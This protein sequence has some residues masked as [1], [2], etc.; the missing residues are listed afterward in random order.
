MTPMLAATLF[1]AIQTTA[2]STQ[3]TTQPA[4][5]PAEPIEII[6]AEASSAELTPQ[7]VARLTNAFEQSLVVIEYVWEG[8]EGRQEL[9]GVGIL[10]DDGVVMAPLD[11]V[12]VV[13]PDAQVSDFKIKVPRRDGDPTEYDAILAGRDERSTVTYFEL[14]EG[15]EALPESARPVKFAETPL[16]PGQPLVSIG[17]LPESAGYT[18]FTT[19]ARVA[20][21]LRG[22]KPTVLVDGNLAGTGAVVFD[23]DGRAVGFVDRFG[24]RSPFLTGATALDVVEGLPQLF[25][26]TSFLAPSLADRPTGGVDPAIPYLGIAR[27][28]GV[29]EDLRDYYGLGDRPAVQVGDIIAGSPADE[30]DV[31]TGDVIV[32][33]DGE[34]LE[35]GDTAD[36][37]PDI[38]NRNIGRKAP[39]TQVT[40]T[41]LNPAREER[42]V[43]V[44][45]GE[46][47]M[48]ARSAERWYAEDLGFSVRELVLGDRY[49]RKIALDSPG[50]A[51]AFVRPQSNA[52]AANL[53]VGDLVRRVNQTQVEDLAQFRE[54]YEAFRESNADDPVVLEV[55]SQGDT[56]IVR[57]E[58]PQ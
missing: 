35:R 52:A 2:P 3:S 37:Q 29:S 56:R 48:Q 33:V 16:M 39:G 44:T 47:P 11:L 51:V 50:V 24:R 14:A 15:Q 9:E 49:E 31:N 19:V 43:A 22:P 4:T 17:R 13:L 1:L 5:R 58:A 41:L 36:E 45:L 30:A 27:A 8:E 55:L 57:I 38:F 34:E 20:T 42:E 46:R 21:N 23:L 12:P 32:A 54:A 40:L 18:T 7:R 26:P 53:Q 10:V 6:Q 25:V 28:V